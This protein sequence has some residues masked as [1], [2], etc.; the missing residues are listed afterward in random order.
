MRL[1]FV[2]G[3][4]LATTLISAGVTVAVRSGQQTAQPANSEPQ[5][6]A[7]EPRNTTD[8]GATFRQI[9]QLSTTEQISRLEQL[10]RNGRS[11]T[12]RS[13]ARY[14]LADLYLQLNRPA[15]A[16]PSLE[17]LERDYP[18]L[19]D[20]V[21]LLRARAYTAARNPGQAQAVWEQILT[22]HAQSPVAAEA[23]YA[24]GRSNRNYWAQA[25]NQFPAHPRSGE[26]ARTLLAQNPNQPELMLLLARY[27]PERKTT[28]PV[29]DRL[30]RSYASRLRAEDWEAVAFGYWQNRQFAKAA[31]AYARAPQSARN[32]YRAGRSLQLSGDSRRA[33]SYYTRV[34]TQFP[35]D[36]DAGNALLR[37]PG[38][39]TAQ[40]A[41]PWLDQAIANHPTRAAEAVLAKAKVYDRSN[42]AQAASAAR[43]LLLSRYANTE[44]AAELSWELARARA[45][46]GDLSGAIQ[47][48]QAVASAAPADSETAPQLMFWAG[49][50]S[51]RLGQADRARGFFQQVLN[52]YPQS[53]YAWRSAGLLGW[54]VGDFLNA[55][56]VAY[57]IQPPSRGNLTAGS[58]QVQE[59]YLLGSGIDAWQ[60]WQAELPERINLSVAQQFTDGLLRLEVN[61]NLEALD[62]ISSLLW[63]DIPSEQRSN[64]EALKQQPYFWEALY[65]MQYREGITTWAQSRNLNPLL[66]MALIRQE[67]RFEPN[68]RSSAGATG[69]MQVMPGTGDWIASKIGLGSYSL[70]N[71]NDN[72]KLGTWYLDYT[73]REYS[74]NSMLAVASYNAGPGNVSSWVRRFGLRDADEFVESIPFSETR[75]YVKLV[76]ENYWNYLRLYSPDIH[77]ELAQFQADQ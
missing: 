61:D 63:Q 34:A 69:L 76:F 37:I 70:S 23:L 8:T 74:N 53:Y 68:I 13:R 40:N 49:K 56:R 75:G 12:E 35:N 67:S 25:I 66:V 77:Q 5:T 33:Y 42:S 31:S 39:T 51:Q 21:L 52:R 7:L 50:W 58:T 4:G 6:I 24:L 9:A 27:S 73:H 64:L 55:R 20:Q 65:P 41:L 47:Q 19:A 44:A 28:V 10:A 18:M 3:L 36:V 15:E 29:L 38:V 46:R 43:N 71:P 11:E 2:L 16:L 48:A 1:S 26:I 14:R 17:G 72:L 30:V 22:E 57:S 62:Q 54:P 32:L 45:Q 60:R 59:L